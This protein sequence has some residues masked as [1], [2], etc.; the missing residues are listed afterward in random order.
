MVMLRSRVS[1]RWLV[2]AAAAVV[3]GSTLVVSG[4]AGAVDDSVK[5]PTTLAPSAVRVEGANRFAT[6]VAVANTAALKSR[7]DVVVAN[8]LD[9]PDG[10]SAAIYKRPV[11]LT[12]PTATPVETMAEIER[13]VA[14][15]ATQGE[16]LGITL[17]GGLNV[18]SSPQRDVLAA[19]TG[20]DVVRVS[21]PDRYATAIA[22]AKA[23]VANPTSVILATGLNFPDALSGGVLAQLKNAPIVLNNGAVLR[24][25]VRAY[26]VSKNLTLS[27]VYVLGGTTVMPASVVA[28]L[29]ALGVN[30]VRLGGADRA[31]TA[32]A[33]AEALL[34]LGPGKDAA[35]RNEVVV[36][37]GD[38][39]ADAL[40]AAPYAYT[41]VEP[42]RDVGLAV[43]KVAPILLVTETAVPATTEAY[44]VANC[45]TI[46][47]VTAVG[48][49]TAIGA[50]VVA[51]AVAAAT[52]AAP[53]VTSAVLSTNT[54]TQAQFIGYGRGTPSY[55]FKAVPG[56]IADGVAGNNWKIGFAQS[57]TTGTNATK[58][59][60]EPATQTG[61]FNV[62]TITAGN[63]GTTFATAAEVVAAFS[64]SNAG[65]V[66][67]ASV[68]TPG[69]D[70]GAVGPAYELVGGSQ[71]ITVDVTFANVSFL[72]SSGALGTLPTTLG[73]FDGGSADATAI[74][75]TPTIVG[76]GV[77]TA[78]TKATYT[79]RA[80]GAA[81]TTPATVSQVPT[82]VTQ[83]RFAKDAIVDAVTGVKNP[84]QVA[85]VTTR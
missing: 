80:L 4:G 60:I 45:V 43:P 31:G 83:I 82:A 3:C 8:G 39:F 59:V 48:G 21:G 33:V 72:N 58:V 78:P 46:K 71:A 53:T 29:Q 49:T 38:G 77:V 84:A 66:I 17:I 50:G 22:V 35:G 76:T 79:F 61:A 30:V 44:Q 20:K 11:L 27:T 9:F 14:V 85:A 1:A 7:C 12:T 6:A 24:D 41:T 26:L 55:D 37:N 56:R 25:D 13:R 34:P 32:V 2:G 23:N 47:T 16:Q 63:S 18:I 28:E 10:L 5:D 15:C 54:F 70:S 65:R 64:N 68:R 57:A 40:T 42:A 51:G 75:G 73:L 67:Q 19:V 62:I 74:V 52:C 69:T 36:V 81:V